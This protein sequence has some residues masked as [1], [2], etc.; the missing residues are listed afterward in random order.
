ML[1]DKWRVEKPSLFQRFPICFLKGYSE[2]QPVI[3][4]LRNTGHFWS[5]RIICVNRPLPTKSS[6]GESVREAII[7]DDGVA[8][9]YITWDCCR[10]PCSLLQQI[11][12]SFL[13]G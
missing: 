2:N 8:N 3:V 4:M 11:N 6:Y 9:V 12:L 10:K 5:I 13:G 1:E 7:K